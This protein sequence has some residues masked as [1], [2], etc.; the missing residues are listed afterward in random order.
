MVERIR[1]PQYMGG[2][3]VPL[4]GRCGAGTPASPQTHERQAFNPASA[5]ARW[6][7]VQSS[8]ILA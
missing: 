5:P 6:G 3:N 4:S 8:V 2:H 1:I 7:R